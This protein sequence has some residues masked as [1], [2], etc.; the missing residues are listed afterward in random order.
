ML[1]GG[2]TR[3]LNNQITLL[4]KEGNYR[5]TDTESA[6]VS[7]RT[8]KKTVKQGGRTLPFTIA[9]NDLGEDLL[10]DADT[11]V[12]VD[13]LSST[14]K[15]DPLSITVV[16]TKTQEPVWFDASVA[17]NTLRIVIP[18]NQPLTVSY[19][20]KV[21]AAPNIAIS[22]KN[23]AHWEGYSTTDDGSVEIKN[24][25]YTV[26]GM[27]GGSATPYVEIL[28]YDESSV[29]TR[30]PGAQF[31][32]V[33]GSM[34]DGVF[35]P[36][37]G[38]SWTGTTDAQGILKFGDAPSLMSYNTVYRIT[39][40]QAPE[41]FV[42]DSTPIYFLVA[43]DDGSGN[44]PAYPEGVDI[45]YESDTYE[46]RVGNGRGEAIIAKL[47]E[48]LGETIA[49]VNGTYTFGIY[50]TEHPAADPMQ[51]VTITFESGQS[52]QN[53]AKF[54]NLELGKSYYI[55]EL[56]DNGKPIPDGVVALVDGKEF[57][58]HYVSG[59]KVIITDGAAAGITITNSVRYP[60]LPETG[61][62]GTNLY[63]AGGLLLIT[64]AVFLLYMNK[65]RK[66]DLESS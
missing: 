40:T 19:N 28:K 45:W 32:M 52:A 7:T 26:G 64:A 6:T 58:V 2:E 36:T 13:Q 57:S 49:A 18:D 54:T 17:G 62:A 24:Y 16:N 4:D 63:I 11:I 22:V 39:E 51:T 47:F 33:E 38:K 53:T 8:L 1:L 14:L 42:P 46:Y 29:V 48:D 60:E 27:A 15:L 5:D 61:G 25:S 65:R 35:T 56:D 3:T 37:S 43:K 41:G 59:P 66:E 50:D 31:E 34:T 30:L 44:Y 9:V 12:I 55:Y 23:S 21:L 10:E 20:A